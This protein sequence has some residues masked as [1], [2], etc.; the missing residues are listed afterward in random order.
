MTFTFSFSGVNGAVA[1]GIRGTRIIQDAMVD[2]CKIDV[3]TIDGI[4]SFLRGKTMKSHPVEPSCVEKHYL[5]S[6]L[7][8]CLAVG[9]THVK[10]KW[11]STQVAPPSHGLLMQ[12]SPSKTIKY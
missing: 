10:L 3:M 11:P 1:L 4:N 7:R 8:P 9:Q 5:H 12:S 6:H 2:I